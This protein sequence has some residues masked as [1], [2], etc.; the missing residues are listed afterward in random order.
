M[1]AHSLKLALVLFALLLGSQMA[2]L[3]FDR[4]SPPEA[5]WS[6]PVLG[7]VQKLR[8]AYRRWKGEN[9]KRGGDRK[10]TLPL[11]WSKGRS[12]E[13]ANAYGETTFDLADRSI[14]VNVNGFPEQEALDVWLVE[15]RPGAQSNVIQE[16]DERLVHVG[17][18]T[19]EGDTSTLHAPIPEE[20]LGQFELDH[21]VV[22]RDGKAPAEGALLLG[23]P[24]LFQRLYSRDYRAARNPSNEH[25]RT[26]VGGLLLA[27][28]APTPAVAASDTDDGLYEL[29]AQGEEL[30]FNEQFNG[31]GRTCGTCHPAENNLTIDR[32]FIATL[33]DNDPL[34]VAEFIP[35]LIFGHPQNLDPDGNPRRFENPTLMR[36]FGLILENQD[37]FGDLANNFNMRG[38]PHVFAQAISI[39]TP[40][41]QLT[42]PDERTGW[43]GDGAP[44]GSIGPLLTTGS[45]RDFA[46]GAI[47]QHFPLTTNRVAG[48]DFRLPTPH[49]LTAIE[50]FMLSLGRQEDPDLSTL[51]LKDPDASAGLAVFNG[52]GKCLNCHF[53]AGANVP[54][55]PPAGTFNFNFNTGV[56]RFLANNP[57][58]TG[59]PRPPDGGFGTNP[60]GDFTSLEL[61]MDPQRVVGSFGDGTFNT[62]SLVEFADTLPAFHNNIT[63]I[64]GDPPPLPD[65]VEGA[66]AFYN[67]AVFQESPGGQA[68][69]GI[70]LSDTE[71][72]QIGKFLRV[73]NALENERSARDLCQRALDAFPP[74]SSPP[75]K[76]PHQRVNRLLRIAIADINDAIEVLGEVGLHPSALTH[77]E[78][79]EQNLV[80]AIVTRPWKKRKMIIEGAMGHLAGARA[81]MKVE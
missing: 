37:G 8:D 20:L 34:F 65:T 2:M 18:L 12:T 71:V 41:G 58:G 13:F 1:K 67:T 24:D 62:P 10:I 27:L 7:N 57:D 16:G 70:I 54:F 53:N 30:F 6:A 21:V 9:A 4:E 28:A 5:K 40:P 49:E 46:V 69:D 55:V 35:A 50:A 14:S 73:I 78:E 64:P 19:H 32:E 75:R 39:V 3:Q 45:L 76:N 79:A 56:E 51:T 63:A 80:I 22:S 17:A 44:F 74:S 72:A 36:Q 42:P 68:V 66:V 15:Y 26:R 60:M 25:E 33:P 81:D 48:V 23:T 31:N 29:I 77:F 47:I 52:A 43:S 59:E 38:V 61:N 11:R